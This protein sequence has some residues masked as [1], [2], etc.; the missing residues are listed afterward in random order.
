MTVKNYYPASQDDYRREKKGVNDMTEEI[1][2]MAIKPGTPQMEALLAAGYPDILTT[3]HAK[4]ILAERKANPL[5]VPYELAQ[6]AEAFLEAY[7]AKA[8]VIDQE[9]GNIY[10]AP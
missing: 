5:M 9:P 6:R 4:E 10:E 7:N 2:K 1:K 3:A 8:I